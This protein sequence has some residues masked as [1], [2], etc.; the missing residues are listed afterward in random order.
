ML[1]LLLFYGYGGSPGGPAPVGTGAYGNH[2]RG[3]RLAVPG[4]W[5]KA[6]TG[7]KFGKVRRTFPRTE[8][9][10]IKPVPQATEPAGPYTVQGLKASDIEWRCYQAL[11]RLG[12]DDSTISFQKDTM[13]GRMPGGQV[14]DFVVHAPVGDIVIAVDGD[15]WHNRTEAQRQDDLFQQQRIVAALGYDVIFIK[16][17]SGDLLTIE[18]G[19]MFLEPLVGHGPALI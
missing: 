18:M 15:V 12:W 8:Y 5:G 17:N 11:L 14:L 9:K 7:Q 1:V 4:S 19:V 16:A 3:V 6:P 10:L 2:P 13:G